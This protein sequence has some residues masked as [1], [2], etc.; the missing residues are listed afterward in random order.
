MSA[1]RVALRREH[2]R[3]PIRDVE[4]AVAESPVPIKCGDL[5]FVAANQLLGALLKVDFRQ[6]RQVA[7]PDGASFGILQAGF[8]AWRFDRLAEGRAKALG[9]GGAPGGG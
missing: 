5:H 7:L 6:A 8:E 2:G 4:H 9:G 3:E 1:A